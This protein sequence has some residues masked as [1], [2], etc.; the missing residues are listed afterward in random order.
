MSPAGARQYRSP[1]RGA[2]QQ[3]TRQR[4]LEAAIAQIAEDGIVELTVPVVAERAG[5]SLRTVYRH[6]PTKDDLIDQVGEYRDAQFGVS[7]PPA[8]VEEL[9]ANTPALFEGFATRDDLVR[10]ADASAAGRQ[11]HDRARRRRAKALSAI[12]EEVTRDLTPAEARRL[13]ATVQVL[14]ST[15]A[16]L[17]LHDNW[18]MDG[19]EAGAAAQ[20]AIATLLDE[21]RR[22]GDEHARGKPGTAS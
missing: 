19:K 3:Q 17:T 14:W 11:V 13:V 18:G 1:L 22:M 9:L 5:V 15:R 20:W 16:W 6:F 8:S 12:F 7:G 10:A 4:I 21:A 2:Q